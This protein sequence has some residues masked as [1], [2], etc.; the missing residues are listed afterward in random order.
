MNDKGTSKPCLSKMSDTEL[1]LAGIVAKYMCSKEER[2]QR[3]PKRTL[4]F[5]WLKSA[6]SGGRVFRA[7]PS[8][9]PLIECE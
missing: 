1:L 5:N 7:Y 4:Q 3:A 2:P 8:V 6:K 9:Q